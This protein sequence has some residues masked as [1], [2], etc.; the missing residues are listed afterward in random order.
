MEESALPVAAAREKMETERTVPMPERPP[1]FFD[2]TEMPTAGWWPTLWPDPAG[3]LASVG[4]KPGMTA[5]DLCCGDGWFTREIAKMARHVV[6]IDIDATMLEAARRYL[7]DAGIGNCDFIQGDAFDLR[8]L[9]PHPV[10]FVFL[11]NVFHGVPDREKLSRAVAD[12]LRPTGL[13][14][15]VNWYPRPREET[16]VLGEPRGPR[17]E[18]RIGVDAVIRA[19]APS[20]LRLVHVADVSPYHYAAVFERAVR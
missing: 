3:V 11:A 5:I 2:G 1:E 16:P 20:G 18:L 17:T 9:W 19:V 10:D 6:A 13:F 12:A 15:V 14:A 8:A 7:A 4:V